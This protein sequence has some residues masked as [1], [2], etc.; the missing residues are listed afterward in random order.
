MS[1]HN[2]AHPI[3]LIA[4]QIPSDDDGTNYKLAVVSAKSF[5]SVSYVIKQIPTPGTTLQYS[6]RIPLYNPRKPS[7]RIMCLNIPKRPVL[8][9]RAR[10][11][12]PSNCLRRLTRSRGNVAAYCSGEQMKR[13]ERH[14]CNQVVLIKLHLYARFIKAMKTLQVS[15]STTI[16]FT[17]CKQNIKAHQT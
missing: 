2:K 4:N 16:P 14:S 1:L 15:W 8:Q 5:F 7:F 10:P 6:G 9:T 13:H 3:L 11:P 17:Q 12:A